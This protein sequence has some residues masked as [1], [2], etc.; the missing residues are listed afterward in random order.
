MILIVVMFFSQL[1][2][3]KSIVCKHDPN[4]DNISLYKLKKDI[5]Y[6]FV[7]FKFESIYITLFLFRV[8]NF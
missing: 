4:L 6:S 5:N 8:F 1:G 7:L 2:R 3:Y